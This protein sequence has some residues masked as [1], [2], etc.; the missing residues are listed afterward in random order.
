MLLALEA[1]QSRV[2]IGCAIVGSMMSYGA[3]IWPNSVPS[4]IWLCVV[5]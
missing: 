5:L 2:E 3:L 1:K 4:Y